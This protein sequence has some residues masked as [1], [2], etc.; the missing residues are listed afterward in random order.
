M[1]RKLKPGEEPKGMAAYEGDFLNAKLGK[2]IAT[3]KLNELT[4]MATEKAAEYGEGAK[5]VVETAGE[6]AK[7]AVDY[8]MPDSSEDAAMDLLPVG[9]VMSLGKKGLGMMKAAPG[10]DKKLMQAADKISKAELDDMAKQARSMSDNPINQQK[11]FDTLVKKRREVLVSPEAMVN[12][13]RAKAATEVFQGTAKKAP[14]V[15]ITRKQPFEFERTLQEAAPG[16][17][18]PAKRLKALRQNRDQGF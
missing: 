12:D 14:E 17:D 18:G 5:D 9:K 7:K 2:S 16:T 3:R 15:V 11:I 8:F 10:I 13:V 6:G 1:A 4:K